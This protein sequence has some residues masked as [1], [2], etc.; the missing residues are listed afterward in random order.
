M[1]Y[2]NLL[3]QTAPTGFWQNI[4]LGLEVIVKDYGLTL[5][6]ITL[7][8]KLIMTP[9]DLY[10]KVIVL[11]NSRKQAKLKPAL[12]K[13]K[14]TYASNQTMLNQKTQE[15]YKREGFSMGGTCLGMLGTMVLSSIVF[16]TLFSALN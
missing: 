9:L 13:L 16:I 5:V 3:L 10:N 6:L 7:I 8:I 4:I 15:L 12:D 1:D 14:T 2:L 11:Y